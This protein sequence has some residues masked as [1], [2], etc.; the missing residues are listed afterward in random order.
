MSIDELREVVEKLRE[1]FDLFRSNDFHDLKKKVD[2]LSTKIIWIMGGF[3]VLNGII[4]MLITI[5]G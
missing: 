3:T 1:D 2:R 5:L 4:W